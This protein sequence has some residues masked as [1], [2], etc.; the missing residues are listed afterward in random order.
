MVYGLWFRDARE[1]NQATQK[2]GLNSEFE[3]G[4]CKLGV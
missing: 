1:F 4:R 3:G 2:T